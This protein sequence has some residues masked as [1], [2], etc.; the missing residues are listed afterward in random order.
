MNEQD[1]ENVTEPMDNASEPIPEDI[2]ISPEI[3]S[4][5]LSDYDIERLAN[6]LVSRMKGI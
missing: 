5:Q 1:F 6:A 2:P 4:C 3:P